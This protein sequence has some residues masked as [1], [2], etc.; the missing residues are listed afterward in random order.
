MV[1]K[2]LEIE[3]LCA[4]GDIVPRHFYLDEFGAVSLTRDMPI[5]MLNKVYDEQVFMF[6]SSHWSTGEDL[7]ALL[8]KFPP[9]YPLLRNTGAPVVIPKNAVVLNYLVSLFNA[10]LAQSAWEAKDLSIVQAYLSVFADPA[11]IN[12]SRLQ[13]TSK[14]VPVFAGAWYATTNFEPRVRVVNATVKPLGMMAKR[15]VAVLSGLD[16][17]SNR[18]TANPSVLQRYLNSAA[19]KYK[20]SFDHSRFDLRHGGT[21]LRRT[22]Q[23]LA[24]RVGQLW[25]LDSNWLYELFSAETNLPAYYPSFGALYVTAPWS[26]LKSGDSKTSR[27]GSYMAWLEAFYIVRTALNWTV[28]DAINRY[29]KDWLLFTFGDDTLITFEDRRLRDVTAKKASAIAERDLLIAIDIE[30]PAGY[31]GKFLYDND[32]KLYPNLKSYSAKTL[33]PERR[34]SA[35]AL[36]IALW[37]RYK[38]LSDKDRAVYLRLVDMWVREHRHFASSRLLTERS[39]AEGSWSDYLKKHGGNAE[40]LLRIGEQMVSD[41]NNPLWAPYLTPDALTDILEILGRGLEHDIDLSNL[42]PIAAY[43]QKKVFLTEAELVQALLEKLGTKTHRST[44]YSTIAHLIKKYGSS[45]LNVS[46]ARELGMDLIRY[47]KNLGL[48]APKIDS[49]EKDWLFVP[50]G[51]RFQNI[52]M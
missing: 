49:A 34:K 21:R 9:T 46:T 25:K 30:E 47:R 33:F 45:L 17:Q 36:P 35:V 11:F 27:L 26:N 41:P 2:I 14:E 20:L 13:H 38:D 16:M 40:T 3:G 7:G 4:I 44:F 23:L 32:S 5:D 12:F 22:I 51:R 29:G 52:K 50:S 6:M 8:R 37:T 1:A 10:L 42:G 31:I 24:N 28:E 48:I 15:I 18:F 19:G 39:N 43:A